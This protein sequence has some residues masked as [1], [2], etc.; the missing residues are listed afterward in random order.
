[1]KTKDIKDIKNLRNFKALIKKYRNTDVKTI[2][3]YRN[4]DIKTIEKYYDKKFAFRGLRIAKEIT[5]FGYTTTCNLCKAATKDGIT[6]CD[7]CAW[8]YFND[9]IINTPCFNGDYIIGETYDAISNATN[10]EELKA[11]FDARANLMEQYL[12]DNNLI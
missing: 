3:K 12:K 10:A 11:A 6:H 5:G 2:E 4:A 8:R 1:M 9:T 7:K